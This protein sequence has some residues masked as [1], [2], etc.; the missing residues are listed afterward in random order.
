MLLGF[1]EIAKVAIFLLVGLG[2]GDGLVLEK[3]WVNGRRVSCD[4]GGI[5]VVA[6]NGL[7]KRAVIGWQ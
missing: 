3:G 7:G 5:E 6:G 1:G 2:E 4:G